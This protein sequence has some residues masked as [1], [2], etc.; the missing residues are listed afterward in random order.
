MRGTAGAGAGVLT[1]IGVM[2]SGLIAVVA[3]S[4]M[5]GTETENIIVTV[6]AGGAGLQVLEGGGEGVPVAVEVLLEGGITVQ[7]GMVVRRDVRE[8]SSGTER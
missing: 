4:M 3:V 7:S 2:R 1:G 8:L 6:I 5:T